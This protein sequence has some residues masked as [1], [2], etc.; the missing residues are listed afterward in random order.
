MENLFAQPTNFIGEG[1]GR[2]AWAWQYPL[3]P[4]YLWLSALSAARVNANYLPQAPH[5]HCL[6]SSLA[7]IQ[8]VCSESAERW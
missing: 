2:A 7:K 3:T 4:L 6:N 5:Q 1:S 8:F